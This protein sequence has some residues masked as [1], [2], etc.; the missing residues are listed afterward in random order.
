MIDLA[1]MNTSIAMLL[2]HLTTHYGPK[3]ELE[4]YVICTRVKS[5]DVEGGRSAAIGGV[6]PASVHP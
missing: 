1:P 4:T 5:P 3:A 2:N 6:G